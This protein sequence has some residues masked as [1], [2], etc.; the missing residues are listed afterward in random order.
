M[1][2]P[3]STS[4]LWTCVFP[5]LDKIWRISDTEWPHFN[6]RYRNTYKP[7]KRKEKK[8]RNQGQPVIVSEIWGLGLLSDFD[9]IVSEL[10]KIIDNPI[11]FIKYRDLGCSLFVDLTTCTLRGHGSSLEDQKLCFVLLEGQFSDTRGSNSIT[12]LFIYF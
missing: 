5:F 10:I 11:V 4:A 12:Y 8:K 9:L 2:I 3:F 6:N 1:P 7:K